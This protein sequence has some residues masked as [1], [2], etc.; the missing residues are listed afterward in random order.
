LV[1]QKR[2]KQMP[3]ERWKNPKT[4]GVG[5]RGS[6]TPTTAMGFTSTAEGGGGRR[7]REKIH[8]KK[9]HQKTPTLTAKGVGRG[10]KISGKNSGR[11]RKKPVKISRNRCRFKPQRYRERVK[12]EKKV[13][14]RMGGPVEKTASKRCAQGR[15]WEG[16]QKGTK[17]SD[18]GN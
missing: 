15:I 7:G 3:P 14:N 4:A 9:D 13:K 12:K 16:G 5:K 11:G 10:N 6:Q 8:R 2:W 17:L 18:D 1:K